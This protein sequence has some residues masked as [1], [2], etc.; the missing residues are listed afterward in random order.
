MFSLPPA[1]S[2]GGAVTLSPL[3]PQCS[4]HSSGCSV[5]IAVGWVSEGLGGTVVGAGVRGTWVYAQGLSSPASG[6][7]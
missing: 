4:A 5:G 1:G 3:G 6:L 7:G 2:K